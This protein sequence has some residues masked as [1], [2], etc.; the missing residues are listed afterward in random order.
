MDLA[1]IITI[2]AA[3]IVGLVTVGISVST[4]RGN[5][6]KADLEALEATVNV[7]RT[8][9]VRYTERLEKAENKTDALRTE[10]DELRACID[11]LEGD[12]EKLHDDIARI[13]AAREKTERERDNLLVK[14]NDLENKRIPAMELEIKKL[15]KMIVDLGGKPPTGPLV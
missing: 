2:V 1:Q 13:Q 4:A 9:N 10:N 15:R 14:I 8:E 11:S 7:L 3:A 6:K 5:A 12:N